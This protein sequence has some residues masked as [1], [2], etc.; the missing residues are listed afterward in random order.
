MVQS[1]HTECWLWYVAV[2]VVGW[3]EHSNLGS[4][5]CALDHPQPRSRRKGDHNDRHILGVS[6]PV[7]KVSPAR[8]VQLWFIIGCLL[9]GGQIN[10]RDAQR[11]G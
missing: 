6:C 1:V 10:K 11:L 2:I 5:S 4:F 9:P 8:C 7:K 3:P